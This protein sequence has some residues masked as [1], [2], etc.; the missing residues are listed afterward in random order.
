MLDIQPKPTN[1]EGT[2]HLTTTKTTTKSAVL[3]IT[4][5]SKFYKGSSCSSSRMFPSDPTGS[6]DVFFF[7]NNLAWGG[8]I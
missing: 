3:T 6:L 2:Y 4:Y 5:N 1:N 7:M 8:K